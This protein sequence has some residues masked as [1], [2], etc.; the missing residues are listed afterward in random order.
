MQVT[1]GTIQKHPDRKD[2]VEVYV[3]GQTVGRIVNDGGWM[4][5]TQL[6]G[7]CG[8]GEASKPKL[9]HWLKSSKDYIKKQL[10][11]HYQPEESPARPTAADIASAAQAR[12]N[13]QLAADALEQAEKMWN[14]A[15]TA[16]INAERLWEVAEGQQSSDDLRTRHELLQETRRQTNAIAATAADAYARVDAVLETAKGSVSI[17]IERAARFLRG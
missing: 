16:Q 15:I 4:S 12:A 8:A 14:A 10:L 13:W 7:H 5:D 6:A 11:L 1:F 17:A 3:D 2:F 9:Y